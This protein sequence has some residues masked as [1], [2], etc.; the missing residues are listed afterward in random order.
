MCLLSKRFFPCGQP[1]TALSAEV[2]KK[3]RETFIKR[4]ETGNATFYSPSR[5]EM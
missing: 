5:Y 2:Q 4:I 3:M 1:L